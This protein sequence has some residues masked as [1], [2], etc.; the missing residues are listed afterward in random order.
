VILE[1]VKA[2]FYIG[3]VDYEGIHVPSPA[4]VVY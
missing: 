2:K 1:I 4:L 3:C